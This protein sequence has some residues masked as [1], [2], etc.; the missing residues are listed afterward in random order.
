[1]SGYDFHG[2][3][4]SQITFDCSQIVDNGLQVAANYELIA[5]GYKPV[6]PGISKSESLEYA[7]RVKQFLVFL[8]Y[9]V[10]PNGVTDED[11]QAYRPICQVLVDRQQMKNEALDLFKEPALS[12]P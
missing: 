2:W 1:M 4:E 9:C 3:L 8:Q 11:W 6:E 10:K 5:K 12:A 7:E